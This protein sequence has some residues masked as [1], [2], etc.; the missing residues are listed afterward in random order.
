MAAG[1]VLPAA[2]VWVTL[3]VQVPSAP[4]RFSSRAPAAQAGELV[5]PPG[6]DR[7]QV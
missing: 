6:A 3:R 2:S 5:P 1:L 7:V 4:V